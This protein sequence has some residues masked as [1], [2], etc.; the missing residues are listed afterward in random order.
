M[1]FCVF[2]T[3]NTDFAELIRPMKGVN[4]FPG[5]AKVS[6]TL[7]V[8][9]KILTNGSCMCPYFVLHSSMLFISW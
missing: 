2:E 4:Y 1:F 6:P 8:I 3:L 9:M 7:L 5:P